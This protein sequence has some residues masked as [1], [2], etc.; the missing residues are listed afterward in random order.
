MSAYY[1]LYELLQLQSTT[2]MVMSKFRMC[3]MLVWGG[4]ISNVIA[5][6]HTKGFRLFLGPLGKSC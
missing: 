4:V 3:L 6:S 2:T 1:I 5:R